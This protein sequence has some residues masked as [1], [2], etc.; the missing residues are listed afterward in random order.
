MTILSEAKAVVQ[1]WIDSNPPG[2]FCKGAERTTL[3][4]TMAV[5]YVTAHEADPK[6]KVPKS[7]MEGVPTPE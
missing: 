6:T 5:T 2:S 1:A 4:D 3:K 7:G